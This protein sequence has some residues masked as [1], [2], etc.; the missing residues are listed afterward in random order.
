MKEKD[1][2][3]EENEELGRERMAWRGQ[4]GGR[5]GK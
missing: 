4:K 5:Q 1:E 2:V 3:I